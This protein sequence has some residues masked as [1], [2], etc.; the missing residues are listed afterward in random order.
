MSQPGRPKFGENLVRKPEARGR[1]PQTRYSSAAAPKLKAGAAKSGRR[2][3][4]ATEQNHPRQ[5]KR[6]HGMTDEGHNTVLAFERA[7]RR[8]SWPRPSA[9][10][11]IALAK[12]RKDRCRRSNS[13]RDPPAEKRWFISETGKLRSGKV[14]A[15]RKGKTARALSYVALQV[16]RA[17]ASEKNIQAVPIGRTYK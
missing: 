7:Q 11:L 12:A 8:A 2:V 17:P 6:R 13:K 14:L 9:E 4:A 3:G 1:E 15:I 16:L 5:A 10:A